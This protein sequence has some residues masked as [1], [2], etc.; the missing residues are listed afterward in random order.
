MNIMFLK[1][2][3]SI[4]LIDGCYAN[5]PEFE[6]YYKLGEFIPLDKRYEAMCE[7]IRLCDEQGIKAPRS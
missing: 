1:E 3:E 2:W 5:G 4:Y 6:G 7:F